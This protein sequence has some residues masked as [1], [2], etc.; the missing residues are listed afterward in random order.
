MQRDGSADDPLGER[1]RAFRPGALFVVGGL[2]I[3]LIL[4]AVGAALVLFTLLQAWSDH[5]A[6]PRHWPE[7]WAWLFFVF[8]FVIWGAFVYLGWTLLSG[9]WKRRSFALELRRHGFRVFSKGRHKDILWTEVQ[10]IQQVTRYQ[11]IR[12]AD[13]PSAEYKV[14][15]TGG[16]EHCFDGSLIWGFDELRKILRELAI[17]KAIPW[18]KV[19]MRS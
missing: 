10:V 5:P 3:G 11:R 12:G 13:M 2:I 6:L 8:M 15:V 19:E 16:A 9:S 17:Q 14:I 1:Y 7:D 4:I 18:E